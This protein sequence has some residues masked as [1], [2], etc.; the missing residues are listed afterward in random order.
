LPLLPGLDFARTSLAVSYRASPDPQEISIQIDTAGIN[1]IPGAAGLMSAVADLVNQGAAGGARFPPSAGF[2]EIVSGPPADAAGPRYAWT[3]RVAAV[4][5][6]YLRNVV[7]RLRLSG[8]DQP[9]TSMSVWGALPPDGTDLSA[10]EREVRGWLDDL[11]AYPGEWPSLGFAL[12][13]RSDR[14]AALR[15]ELED[16]ITAEVYT[17][18]ER[19]FSLWLEG[20][21]FYVRNDGAVVYEDMPDFVF[22][23]GVARTEYQARLTEFHH[24]PAPSRALLVNL[25]CRF[26]ERV[27]PIRQVELRL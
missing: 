8:G 18:L 23:S 1:V 15:V 10:T 17:E 14:G 21:M 6:L 22:R 11:Q 27:A 4:D 3:L 24:A 19:L 13:H 12:S 20:V 5:P 25:L 2:A 9:V 16:P 26:H 7:E